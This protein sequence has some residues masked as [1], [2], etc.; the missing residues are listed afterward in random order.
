[1]RSFFFGGGGKHLDKYSYFFI[2]KSFVVIFFSNFRNFDDVFL[3]ILGSCHK[4]C[5]HKIGHFWPSPP[6]PPPSKAKIW[7]AD[8]HLF[9]DDFFEI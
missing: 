3:F 4:L 1:M 2:K 7:N 5:Q 9:R 8:T 6:V